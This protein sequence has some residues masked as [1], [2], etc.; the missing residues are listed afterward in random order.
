MLRLLPEERLWRRIALHQDHSSL[1]GI[2][3]LLYPL[4]PLSHSRAETGSRASRATSRKVE[5]GA[6]ENERCR[7]TAY[8]NS[9]KVH[10]VQ[11]QLHNVG[12]YKARLG[13]LPEPLFDARLALPFRSVPCNR[14]CNCKN[15]G[16]NLTQPPCGLV[17][18]HGLCTYNTT[19][20][21]LCAILQTGPSSLGRQ[22]TRKKEGRKEK[23]LREVRVSLLGVPVFSFSFRREP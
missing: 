8:R 13:D 12:A 10:A 11:Y 1:G 19:L 23:K 14:N 3:Q 4:F 16:E 21:E 6:L 9:A 20:P 15:A 5:K 22:G 17:H 18:Y 2:T 7:D